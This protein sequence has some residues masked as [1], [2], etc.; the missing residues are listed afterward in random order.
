VAP[1]TI[2]EDGLRGG[3]A[4]LDRAV[5]GA[6]DRIEGGLAGDGHFPGTSLNWSPAA[7]FRRAAHHQKKA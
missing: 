2:V 6:L 7:L 3:L 4:I 1:L 5:S